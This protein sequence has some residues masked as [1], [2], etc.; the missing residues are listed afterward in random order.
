MRGLFFFLVIISFVFSGCKKCV[1]CEIRLKQSQQV[2]GFIDEF[3]GNDKKIEKEEAQLRA[4]YNCIEC[5]VF[6][7]NANSGVLCGDRTY[8]DSIRSDWQAG[9]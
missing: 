5:S 2:I 8:T 7:F 4:D 6:T 3:C 1:Q 9:A